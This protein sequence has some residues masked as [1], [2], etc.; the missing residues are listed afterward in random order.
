MELIAALAA[1][2]F[3][4]AVLG[5]VGAGGAMLSVPILMYLFDFAPK[6][7]TTAALAV[8]FLAALS[9]AI[10]KARNKQ[11][12]YR[13][14]LVISG[15]GTATNIGFSL[16]VDR[17]PDAFITT[18]FALVLLFA[19]ASMLK[20][21][22]YESHTRMPISILIMASLVIGSMTGLFGIGGGFLAIPILVLFFG[23]PQA[24]AA[25]TSL[26]IIA[27]NSLIS[28]LGH[29]A[30]WDSVD[31]HVPILMAIA[32]VLIAQIA[33]HFSSKTNPNILRKAF[34]YLLFS[35]S[36]FTFLHTWL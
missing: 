3:I 20:N 21:P 17:L 29:H 10:P 27:M 13:D 1:G 22:K 26:A 32:A 33:S 15:L 31:W 4:G 34:A 11:I 7:A 36:I 16:V 8:V 28:F 18:G 35:V 12:L 2:S 6:E 30:L 5:F 19:G 14:A 24:I 9:G 23:T 25:G